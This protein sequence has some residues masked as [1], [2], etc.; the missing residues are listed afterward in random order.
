MASLGDQVVVTRLLPMV[1]IQLMKKG[2]RNHTL[3]NLNGI[4]TKIKFNLGV[5][6]NRS[7]SQ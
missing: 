3:F 2:G 1:I 4:Q 5:L 7:R 6:E